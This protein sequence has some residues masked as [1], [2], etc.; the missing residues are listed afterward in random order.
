[1]P[2]VFYVYRFPCGFLEPQDEV[3]PTKV[4]GRD[5]WCRVFS[6]ELFHGL[7]RVYPGGFVWGNVRYGVVVLL[8]DVNDPVKAVVEWFREQVMGLIVNYRCTLEVGDVV[9]GRG[10][11]DH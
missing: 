7:A 1:M 11:G 3:C 5:V 6:E 8:V 4:L 10:V 9:V 2:L